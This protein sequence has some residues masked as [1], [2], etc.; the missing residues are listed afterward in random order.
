MSEENVQR[1]PSCWTLR[2]N[3]ARPDTLPLPPFTP[4]SSDVR[5]CAFSHDRFWALVG[6]LFLCQLNSPMPFSAKSNSIYSMK[7]FPLS[8]DIV[9]FIM[10]AVL[11]T[12]LYTVW[13][14]QISLWSR[15]TFYIF[16]N[17]RSTCTE[18]V[19]WMSYKYFLW[20]FLYVCNDQ[21]K[22]KS[23]SSMYFFQSPPSERSSYEKLSK[24]SYS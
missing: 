23:S 9:T 20:L 6:R 1:K 5:P 10:T 16:A 4:A 8:H 14:L 12:S 21:F 2:Q 7:Y 11:I 24:C 18:S 15:I 19:K 17:P 22:F 3:V 13:F